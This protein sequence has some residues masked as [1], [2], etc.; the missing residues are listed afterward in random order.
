VSGGGMDT[1]L[2]EFLYLDELFVSCTGCLTPEERAA[3][4][5]GIENCVGPR[6]GM[7]HW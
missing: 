1:W 5:H 6:A 7:T 4:T 3:G 2:Y